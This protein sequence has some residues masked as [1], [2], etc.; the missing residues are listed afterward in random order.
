MTSPVSLEALSA[1]IEQLIHSQ[2]SFQASISANLNSLTSEFHDIR[3]RLPPPGFPPPFPPP[4]PPHFPAT[5]MK[6]DIPRFDGSDAIGWIFK[7][8]SSFSI[9]TRRTTNG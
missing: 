6:L 1:T 3:A 2:Q 8:T 9:I 7:I 4:D 5:T